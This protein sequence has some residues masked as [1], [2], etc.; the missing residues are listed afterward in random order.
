M[1]TLLSDKGEDE[2]GEGE[3]GPLKIAP[4]ED[5]KEEYKEVRRICDRKKEKNRIM[6]LVMWADDVAGG[7]SREPS[8]ETRD[9]L[10]DHMDI[11]RAY[12]RKR[13]EKSLATD[14]HALRAKAEKEQ[15]R[16]E[17]IEAQKARTVRKF[18][19]KFSATE[20]HE[21]MGED[22]LAFKVG[23]LIIV[24][25][26]NGDYWF[27]VHA[28]TGAEGWVERVLLEPRALA[29][30]RTKPN[31]AAGTETASAG[32]KISSAVSGARLKLQ[33]Y[34]AKRRASEAA[35]PKA[36]TTLLRTATAHA[37]ADGAAAVKAAADE[38]EAL[39]K[40]PS[41]APQAKAGKKVI[42]A[43]TKCSKSDCKIKT[44][45]RCRT[46]GY[47]SRECQVSSQS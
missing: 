1:D 46:V 28:E 33:A 26:Q 24:E 2:E 17:R 11:V 44:C 9:S 4:E 5:Y 8:W 37:H 22:N 16:K 23:D 19:A 27:C 29:E 15:E 47:C 43:C 20:D 31:T 40:Q 38:A 39:S 25:E 7:S 21:A 10:K 45:S 13:K 30:L 18:R 35:G 14:E 3:G 6:Y 32:S 41:A 12:E 34:M 36:T 42:T